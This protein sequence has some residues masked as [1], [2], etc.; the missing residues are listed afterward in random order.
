M[1]FYSRECLYCVGSKEQINK[2]ENKFKPLHNGY[3]IQMGY[4]E[5]HSLNRINSNMLILFFGGSNSQIPEKLCDKIRTKYEVLV[6]KDWSSDLDDYCIH[7]GYY[8]IDGIEK[9]KIFWKNEELQ[10]PN[11]DEWVMD[12]SKQYLRICKIKKIKQK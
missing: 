7:L 10:S 8:D 3:Q 1:G 9:E 5:Y 4:S 6:Y 12:H 11:I 2:L